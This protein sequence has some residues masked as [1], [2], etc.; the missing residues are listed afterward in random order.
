MTSDCDLQTEQMQRRDTMKMDGTEKENIIFCIS[1]TLSMSNWAVGLSKY[2]SGIRRYAIV[3]TESAR[4][5]ANTVW[6]ETT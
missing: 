3:C 1:L 4:D 6:R 5:N 2:R